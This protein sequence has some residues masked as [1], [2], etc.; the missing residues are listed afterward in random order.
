MV[1]R[2][3]LITDGIWPYVLGGMQKHSYYLCKYLAQNK[4][5]VDVYHF[6]QS[7][8]DI[9]KLEIFTAEEK[10]YIRSIIIDF[11]KEDKL[12]GHYIRASYKYSKK[13]YNVLLPNLNTYDFIYTKGFSG[14]HLIRKKYSKKIKC[15]NIGVKFHGYEMFQTAPAFKARLQQILFLRKP[16]KE[17]SKKADV[18]FSY[19]SKITEII[20]GI[21]V[22]TSKIIE[23]PSGVESDSILNEIRETSSPLKFIFVGRYERRKGIEELNEALKQLPQNLKYE[24]HFIGP[25][26]ENKKLSQKNIIYHSEIRDKNNLSLILRN[27]DVLVCASWSEGFPNVILEAM[28]K[29]LCIAASNTGATNLL[30]T[31]KTGWIIEIPTVRELKSMLQQII[32]SSAS[33]LNDKK[34]QSLLLVKEK[35]TWEKLIIEL[36][37]KL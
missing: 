10:K 6:N 4:I 5:E 2:I 17:I 12:P 24:F 23:I 28:A 37:E 8:L 14:W 3:A 32:Q 22:N 9:S 25:I 7:D 1:K 26:P 11:P 15:C 21:G 33:Q 13:I 20:K 36:I 35:F 34:R 16:V 31:D 30:V 19:G 29:G 18:V 27:C